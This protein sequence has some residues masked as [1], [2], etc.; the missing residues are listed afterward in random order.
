MIKCRSILFY[1]ECFM[2]FT[3]DNVK[4]SINL[5]TEVF[6]EFFVQTQPYSIKQLEEH[7]SPFI[8][9]PSSHCNVYNIPSPQIYVHT[10]LLI[11]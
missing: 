11:V 9:L 6:V 8:L 10:L 5:Q 2:N 4:G 3:K 1:P 7:P